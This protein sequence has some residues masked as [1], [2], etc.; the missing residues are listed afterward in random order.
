MTQGFSLGGE[1]GSNTA[2]LS[3]A[4]VPENRGLVVSWQ[5]ASQNLA[6]VVGGL[7]G[8]LLTAVLPASSLDAYGWRIAFLLGAGDGTFRVVAALDA[9]GDP[10][11][12]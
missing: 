11:S 10:T 7:V 8:V 1:I 6:L 12:G 9:A 5:G 4:S 3:E 2:Y